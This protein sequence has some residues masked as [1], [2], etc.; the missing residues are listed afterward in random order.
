[1]IKLLIGIYWGFSDISLNATSSTL[2]IFLRSVEKST[3]IL[4]FYPY[5]HAII[6]ILPTMDVMS[7]GY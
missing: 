1:M 4:N 5:L 6:C 7:H 3:R 2:I